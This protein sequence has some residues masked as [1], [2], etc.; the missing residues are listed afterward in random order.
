M[1]IT[2]RLSEIK[3]KEREATGILTCNLE[4][5]VNE[6]FFNAKIVRQFRQDKSKRNQ[7][8]NTECWII[9]QKVD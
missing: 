6:I 2:T 5:I 4:T 8:S 3:S 7:T 1:T 9:P